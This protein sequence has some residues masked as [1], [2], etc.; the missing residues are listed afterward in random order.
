MLLLKFI[1]Q[2]SS[3]Q[4]DERLGIADFTTGEK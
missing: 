3:L 1:S 4:A 2:F